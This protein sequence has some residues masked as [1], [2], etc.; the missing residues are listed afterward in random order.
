MGDE[1]RYCIGGL[2]SMYR[3]KLF[4]GNYEDDRRD[5]PG[6]MTYTN[7]DTLEGNFVNGLPNGP[8]VYTFGETKKIKLA[9]YDHGM[10]K[11]WVDLK[12]RVQNKPVQKKIN[13]SSNLSKL[14]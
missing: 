6:I 2:G 14:K 7:G 11:E 10:R 5:G 13:S 1:N 12:Q 8:I 4:K 3:M 9:V